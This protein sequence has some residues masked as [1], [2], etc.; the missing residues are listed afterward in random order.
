MLLPPSLMHLD[1]NWTQWV[2]KRTRCKFQGSFQAMNHTRK[3]W[4]RLAYFPYFPCTGRWYKGETRWNDLF[5]WNTAKPLASHGNRMETQKIWT[6]FGPLT[7]SRPSWPTGLAVS[8][9]LLAQTQL[10]PGQTVAD[11]DGQW[12]HWAGKRKESSKSPCVSRLMRC[13][14]EAGASFFAPCRW[15]VSSSA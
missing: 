15:H 8:Q 14:S 12:P 7:K 4:Y 5:E 13:W 6:L 9:L 2:W 3:N 1:R 10:Q 11:S